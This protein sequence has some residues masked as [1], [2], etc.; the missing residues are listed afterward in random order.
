MAFSVHSARTQGP[1]SQKRM[2]NLSNTFYNFLYKTC[3]SCTQVHPKFL[4]I[5]PLILRESVIS[6][7]F[8]NLWYPHRIPSPA[9]VVYTVGVKSSEIRDNLA[10]VFELFPS[11]DDATRAFCPPFPGRV[12]L[13]KAKTMNYVYRCTHILQDKLLIEISASLVEIL[14]YVAKIRCKCKCKM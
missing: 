1:N 11:G 3:L 8:Q 5:R 7:V 12:I 6:P 4:R 10:A 13:K 2:I 9:G 14:W